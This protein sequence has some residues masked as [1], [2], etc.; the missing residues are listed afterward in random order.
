VENRPIPHYEPLASARNPLYVCSDTQALGSNINAALCVLD[1]LSSCPSER[2]SLSTRFTR[3]F[4]VSYYMGDYQ[5]SHVQPNA[6][7]VLDEAGKAKTP[8]PPPN[9]NFPVGSVAG[10]EYF[11]MFTEPFRCGFKDANVRTYHIFSLLAAALSDNATFH[12]SSTTRDLIVTDSSQSAVEQLAQQF[13]YLSKQVTEVA[14]INEEV[15]FPSFVVILEDF[16]DFL[17]IA[18]NSFGNLAFTHFARACIYKLSQ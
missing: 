7:A 1:C 14:G 8:S 9:T 13:H 15:S 12:I 18:P 11:M 16:I 2:S 17:H 10:I 5:Q 3:V 4:R 6:L